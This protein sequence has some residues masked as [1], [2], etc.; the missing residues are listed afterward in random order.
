[1]LAQRGSSASYW[2]STAR[3]SACH[4]PPTRRLQSDEMADLT[5]HFAVRAS[6]VSLLSARHSTA[7]FPLLLVLLRF[8]G[9]LI[10]DTKLEV[11]LTQ[12]S[13]LV[14]SQG[15]QAWHSTVR[16]A[17]PASCPST[18]PPFAGVSSKV[19]CPIWNPSI[20][21]SKNSCRDFFHPMK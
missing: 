10:Q 5:A 19:W 21:L 6:S 12:E 1:M 4:I 15:K 17:G 18:T 11:V 9:E 8:L 13:S 16:A 3:R 20:A 7:F 2:N 14:L